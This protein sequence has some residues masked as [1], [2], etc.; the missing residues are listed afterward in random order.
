MCLEGGVWTVWWTALKINT[1][2]ILAYL[3][4]PKLSQQ[5]LQFNLAQLFT[6]TDE[7]FATSAEGAIFSYSADMALL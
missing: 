2:L 3:D 6:T 5:V 7:N 1:E 4:I